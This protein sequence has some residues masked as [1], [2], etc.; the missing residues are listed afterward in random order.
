MDLDPAAEEEYRLEA[1]N[2]E[3]DARAFIGID[4]DDAP[5][6]G[7][8][9]GSTSPTVVD[10]SNIGTSTSA[11]IGANAT[12]K[13]SKVWNDFEELT[14]LVNGK[15]VRY[16]ALCKYYKKTF[17]AKSSCGT[18]HLLRHNCTAKKEQQ[19]SGI[20]RPLLEYNPDG[21]LV[22]WEYSPTVARTELC[23]L[24]AR[25]DLPL[26]FGD[27]SLVQW[28]YSPVVARTE[29]CRLIARE[30]LPLWFG[31]SDAFQEYITKAH[32]PKFVKS[33]RQTTAR[34]LIKL[35]NERVLKLIESFKS[36]SSVALTSD[37]WNGKAIEDYI[38]V[39]AHFVNSNWELDKRL[40]GLRLIDVKHSGKNIAER[41]NMVA[42]E[43]G[44]SD[45]ML[46]C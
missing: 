28:E 1:H 14:N 10:G 31:E 17:S 41:V 22:Q 15:R 5:G 42:D 23:R 29:L 4:N 36:V 8:G 43:Y 39:V 2:E 37:I 32:N 27:G 19:C 44:L 30:D 38:S 18:G 24:I 16:G 45:T 11:S 7:T 34:D 21:S 33:S 40:I 6:D 20:V 25:E 12:R 3:Q 35:Y 13:R 46:T 9:I 26:W